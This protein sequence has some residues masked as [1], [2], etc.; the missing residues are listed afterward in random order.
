MWILNSIGIKVLETKIQ[1]G[2]KG[3]LGYYVPKELRLSLLNFSSTLERHY[4]R[5]NN[6]NRFA[7]NPSVL[8]MLVLI[9]LAK[10][11]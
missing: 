5:P 6:K 2:S 8:L 4:E 3:S 7:L 1:K 11:K 10:T 9:Q